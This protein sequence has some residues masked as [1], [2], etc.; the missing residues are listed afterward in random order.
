M[1]IKRIDNISIVLKDLEAGIAFFTEL[2]LTLDGETTVEGEW[3][4]KVIG[5]G[6]VKSDI[7]MMRAPDGGC[8]LELTR[9]QRPDAVGTVPDTTPAN[10]YGIRRIMF[11]VDDLDDT[12]ARLQKLGATLVDEVVQYGDAYRLC[13]IRGPEGIMLALAEELK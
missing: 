4:G 13:Y 10:A 5:L 3:V 7:A 9:F 6:D 1:A 11:A 8:A 12:L 2:G